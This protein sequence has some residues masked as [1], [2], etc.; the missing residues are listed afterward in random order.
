[1]TDSKRLQ[2]LEKENIELRSCIQRL[3]REKQLVHVVSYDLR[4]GAIALGGY[5]KFLLK[6]GSNI[7]EQ[8]LS[9]V[10]NTMAE[11][12]SKATS[13]LFELEEWLTAG[14]AP[15]EYVPPFLKQLQSLQPPG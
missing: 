9:Q 13:R 10:L 8:L 4:T 11:H 6:R 1:M 15:G 2:E 3:E 12:V 5:T 14:C 7:N